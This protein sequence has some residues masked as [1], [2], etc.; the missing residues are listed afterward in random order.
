MSEVVVFLGNLTTAPYAIHVAQAKSLGFTVNTKFT[1]S[2]NYVVCSKDA[3]AKVGEARELGLTILNEEEWEGII[4]EHVKQN[5][6]P[7]SRK[8]PRNSGSDDI[9]EDTDVNDEEDNFD[10]IFDKPTTYMVAKIRFWEIRLDGRKT[11]IRTGKVGEKGLTTMK[12]HRTWIDAKE[13][14][15]DLI[16]RKLKQGFTKQSKKVDNDGVDD[17]SKKKGK[18]ISKKIKTNNTK[19]DEADAASSELDDVNMT[20]VSDIID[21]SVSENVNSHSHDQKNYSSSSKRIKKSRV[22]PYSFVNTAITSI[23]DGNKPGV[24]L[25]DTWKSDLDPTG[26]WISEKLDGVR[27]FWCGKKGKFFSR[28]GNVYE[29]PDWFTKDLPRDVD[30]DGEL[31]GGRGKF[32]STVSIVKAGKEEWKSIT[33]EIFD[34]PSYAE[35]PFEDRM[36]YLKDLFKEKKTTYA[37]I[38]EQRRCKSEKDIFNEL[39]HVES[40]GAEG[41]MLRKP[42]SKYVCGRSN[43][44]LKVKSFFDGEALVEGYEPGKGKYKG[45]TGALKCAMACGTKFKVGSGMTDYNRSNPPK[46]GSIIVY[47]CQELSDSGNPRFPIFVGVSADKTEPKDPDFEGS[48]EW[49]K[50]IKSGKV[51]ENYFH[52]F[53]WHAQDYD[54]QAKYID[55]LKTIDD[56]KAFSKISSVDILRK[57]TV[58]IPLPVPSFL[59]DKIE[60][61]VIEIRNHLLATYFLYNTFYE[62]E[63]E[64]DFEDIKKIH[65]ILLKDTQIKRAELKGDRIH[66]TF[67]HIH[68]FVDGSGPEKDS[69]PS[70]SLVIQDLL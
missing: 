37:R 25:A 43:T 33:Y 40:L 57:M 66:S 2:T 34:V 27:A 13:S 48:Q 7:V 69:I 12:E 55:F 18:R 36:S 6:K 28:L 60:N 70:Y 5:I 30:L 45:M 31:F 59:S 42:K 62:L 39:K 19:K 14:M 11:Y 35:T 58:R 47:K 23:M 56:L 54:F 15:T 44:L 32:Q 51:W 22:L 10:D 46:I 9:K 4:L 21:N 67:L 17:N 68:P 1:E 49:A 64:I 50:L 63:R 20:D 8:R 3:G 16:E 52:P 38:V 29:A 41:L 65:R 26:W 53:E 61:E 24:L